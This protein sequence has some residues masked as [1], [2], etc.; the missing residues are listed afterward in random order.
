MYSYESLKE[1]N[2]KVKDKL[3]EKWVS[4]HWLSFLSFR[5]WALPYSLHI[6]VGDTDTYS[7]GHWVTAECLLGHYLFIENCLDQLSL[8]LDYSP[9][10]EKLN[11]KI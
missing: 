5:P 2:F 4:V 11:K 7:T 8:K 6:V 1:T 3:L 9:C 10:F